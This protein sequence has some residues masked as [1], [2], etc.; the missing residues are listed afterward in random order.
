M[1]GYVARDLNESLWFHYTK[2]KR[3]KALERE[4]YWESD[5]KSFQIH[6]S[7]FPEFKDL[8]WQDK[9]IAVG[10]D[11]HKANIQD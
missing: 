10:F 6:D 2:P 3:A 1:K 5:D 9:P 11:I 4:M 7:D 8:K